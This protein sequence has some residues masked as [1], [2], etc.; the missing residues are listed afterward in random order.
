MPRIIILVAS[1]VCAASL[2]ASPALA[3]PAPVDNVP[4]GTGELETQ[5]I[6]PAENA[7]SPTVVLEH[8]GGWHERGTSLRGEA[9][10]LQREGFAVFKDEYP[11]D[12]HAHAFPSEPEA[13]ERATRWAIEHGSEYNA[14]PEDVVLLGGSAGGQLAAFAAER[15]DEETPSACAAGPGPVCAVIS[16]SGPMSLPSLVEDGQR[17]EL[18]NT[19]VES[20][21]TAS[22]CRK[23]GLADCPEPFARE[24]SPIDRIP[25][26]ADCPPWLLFG[27]ERD[28]VPD[29]QQTQMASALETAGCP[30]TNV[31]VPGG[32]HAFAYWSAKAEGERVKERV[33]AFI[34]AH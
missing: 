17:A 14:S 3:E 10:L 27:S 28:L 21:H 5:A 9:R 22:E 2:S 29:S 24:W 4:Y 13:V 7:G 32:A 30:V 6:Y 20:L 11:L 23:V 19:L 34:K 26:V 18:K 25:P 33:A 12:N 1:V 15:I 8:E 31:L 16:L